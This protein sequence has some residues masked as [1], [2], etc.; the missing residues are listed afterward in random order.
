MEEKEIDWLIKEVE[1]IE[2]ET[3]ENFPHYVVVSKDDVLNAIKQMDKPETV[4]SVIANYFKAA[5]R[6]KEVLNMEIEEIE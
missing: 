6:M 1:K 2:E 3:S 4:A 5:S